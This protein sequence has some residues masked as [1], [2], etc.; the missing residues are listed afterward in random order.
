[1]GMIRLPFLAIFRGLL[2]WPGKISSIQHRRA[3]PQQQLHDHTSVNFPV[4]EKITPDKLG[5]VHETGPDFG[6]SEHP[7]QALPNFP[8]KERITPVNFGS[9]F[10]SAEHSLSPECVES[11]PPWADFGSTPPAETDP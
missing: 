2:S 7:G 6:N 11:Q 1:M 5:S 3:P 10:G 4:K 8:P 9:A